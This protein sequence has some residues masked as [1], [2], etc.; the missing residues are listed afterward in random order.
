VSRDRFRP[1]PNPSEAAQRLGV[2]I[3]ALRLYERHGLVTP[4]RTSVGWRA[5]GPNQMARAAE[6]VALR[7]LGL[8]LAQM[9]QVLGG[10]PQGL[11]PALAAHQTTLEGRVRQLGGTIEKVRS[12]R[13]DLARGQ[14]P[15][16]GELALLIETAAGFS[17]AFDLPWPWTRSWS[18]RAKGLTCRSEEKSRSPALVGRTGVAGRR[19]IH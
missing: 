1:V 19:A 16:A 10:A 11:Q 2:S 13:A 12:L 6:I 18:A 9:A 5:Y 4:V 17:I 14:A 3:E 15:T 8:S 7:A